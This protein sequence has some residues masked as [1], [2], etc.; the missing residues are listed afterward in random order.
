MEVGGHS[1][2]LRLQTLRRLGGASEIVKRHV[3][4]ALDALTTAERD[5]AARIF[6][7]LVTPAGSKIALG[8]D[9]LY[10]NAGMSAEQ[11]RALLIKLSLYQSTFKS[12]ASLKWEFL[13]NLDDQ[14]MVTGAQ[15]VAT[16]RV[17]ITRIPI[18][19][20]QLPQGSEPPRRF[21]LSKSSQGWTIVRLEAL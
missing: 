7:S 17:N 9:D 18:G 12:F 19:G 1:H 15:A 21:T 16:S 6:Q 4:S 14:I 10:P 5:A 2:V 20:R 8:V 11:L 13:D 3:D